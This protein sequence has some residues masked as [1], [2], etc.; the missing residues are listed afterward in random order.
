MTAI[1]IT[2]GHIRHGE[3]SS[4]TE[5]PIALAIHDTFPGLYDLAVSGE[6]IWI[7]PEYD[8]PSYEIP[9]PDAVHEFVW[10]YDDGEPVHPFAF[11]LDYPPAVQR[12]A[13]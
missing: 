12:R 11:D 4:C 9:A 8:G 13:A 5:C 2:A 10:D 1:H 7:Q 3:Q 6:Q